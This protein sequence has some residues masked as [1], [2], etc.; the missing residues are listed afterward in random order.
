MSFKMQKYALVDRLQIL[1]TGLAH[2]FYLFFYQFFPHFFADV[3]YHTRVTDE[4]CS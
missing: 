3:K 2:F 1:L 4:L